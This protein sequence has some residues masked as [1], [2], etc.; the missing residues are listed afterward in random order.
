MLRKAALLA[1]LLGAVLFLA[2]QTPSGRVLAVALREIA[3]PVHNIEAVDRDIAD[4]ISRGDLRFAGVYGIDI[5]APGV[6]DSSADSLVA[7][8]G[9]KVNPFTTDGPGT[10]YRAKRDEYYTAYATAYNSR[11]LNYILRR[12]DSKSAHL[13][14]RARAEIQFL[15]KR[16]PV[17]DAVRD[18]STGRAKFIAIAGWPTPGIPEADPYNLVYRQPSRWLIASPAW[19]RGKDAVQLRHAMRLYVQPYNARLYALWVKEAKR[20]G[21]K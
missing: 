8:H 17:Q 10:A 5:V 18:Y 3:V 7:L 19:M 15:Q 2:C 20:P 11:L 9:I 14:A 4:A 13:F 12:P 6:P 1:V 21:S 16:N